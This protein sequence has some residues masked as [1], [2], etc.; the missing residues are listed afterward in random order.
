MIFLIKILET[1]NQILRIRR[2]INKRI[3]RKINKV[4]YRSWGSFFFFL[5]KMSNKESQEHVLGKK[6]K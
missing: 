2:K 4:K 5:I 6:N 1:K 3:R